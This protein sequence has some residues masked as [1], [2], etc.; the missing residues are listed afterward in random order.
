MLVTF[1][2]MLPYRHVTCMIMIKLL[3]YIFNQ[4]PKPQCHQQTITV[5]NIRHQHRRRHIIPIA[6]LILNLVNET[7]GY[8]NFIHFHRL[9]HA[10]QLSNF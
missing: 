1:F 9:A 8:M 10:S 2:G 4:S 7:S 6:D 3:A 5:S